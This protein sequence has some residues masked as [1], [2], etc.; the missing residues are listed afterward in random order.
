M[1][2]VA[3]RFADPRHVVALDPLPDEDDSGGLLLSAEGLG[4]R[5][6]CDRPVGAEGRPWRVALGLPRME[7]AGSPSGLMIELRGDRSGAEVRLECSDRQGWGLAYSLGC[8]DFAD[9]RTLMTRLRMPSE[10]WGDRAHFEDTALRP[11]FVLQNLVFRI[12][13]GCA[14]ID[15]VLHELRI[16]GTVQVSPFGL[17]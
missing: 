2:K 8:V 11:P 9:R 10:V 14:R 7:V 3:V 12:D 4:L 17:A 6:R 5:V 1:T 16:G 13:A 15:V